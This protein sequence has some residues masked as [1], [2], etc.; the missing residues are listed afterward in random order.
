MTASWRYENP[1]R[2][3]HRWQD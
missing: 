1:S 2:W 3:V